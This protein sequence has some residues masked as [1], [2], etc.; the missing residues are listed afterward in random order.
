M[1]WWESGEAVVLRIGKVCG[2]LLSIA[3]F[4][5][6][7]IAAG[8]RIAGQIPQTSMQA[9]VPVT[10]ALTLDERLTP[11]RIQAT[12]SMNN[13]AVIRHA[14]ASQTNGLPTLTR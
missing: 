9:A 4:L 11:L 12:A 10:D 3:A 14:G 13:L 8:V 6:I 1:H 7:V 2:A 5:S